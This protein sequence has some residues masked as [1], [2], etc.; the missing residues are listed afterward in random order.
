MKPICLVLRTSLRMRRLHPALFAVLM[1]AVL[2]RAALVA[3]VPFTPT[4]DGQVIEQL[5]VSPLDPTWRQVRGLRQQ[6]A[7]RPDNLALAVRV[8]WLYIEQGRALSEPRYYGYAEG[9]L[10]PWWKAAEPPVPILVLRATIRQHDHDFESALRDL[11]LA[12]RA[13]PENAQAWLTQ[14]VVQQVRG[15]YAAAR[16]SCMQVLRLSDPLVAV[17]CLST[18]DSLTG[19]GP[20]AYDALGRALTRARSA[21]VDVQRWAQTVLAETAARTNQASQ[22]DAHFQEALALGP[23]DDYLRAAYADFLLD[24]GRPQAVIDLLRASTRVDALL[25]RLALAEQRVAAPELDQHVQALR[26]RFAAA[27][28]RGD[29]VHQREEARFA[30]YLLRQPQAALELARANWA[31]QREPADA[32]LLLEAALAAGDPDAA[33]PVLIFLADS[34]LDDVQLTPLHAKLVTS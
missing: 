28:L 16:D 2:S 7:E 21:P 13:D 4:D 32:R 20:K 10:A 11:S 8:A 22:A 26:D 19:N 24:Q 27:R 34:G 31:V 29:A 9:V 18:I 6:L 25:L 3:A 5:P 12:L 23:T 30:L 17:T 33:Q 14:A 1:V 15:D